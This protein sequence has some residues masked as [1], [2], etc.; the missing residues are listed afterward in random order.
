LASLG[1]PGGNVTGI[2]KQFEIVAAKNF[3]PLKE[4]KP[5][6]TRIGI[7][8]S[9]DNTPSA[10]TTKVMQEEVAP[11]LDLTVLPIGV[12]KPEDFAAAFETIIRERLEAFHVLPVPV[13]F[14]NRAK[15]ADFA[16]QRQL[17]TTAPLDM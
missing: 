10:R 14:A 11:R 1:R 15:I 3:E 4:S 5:G 6:I 2:G 12:T 16:M 17:L 13:E 9:P 7:I 8:F